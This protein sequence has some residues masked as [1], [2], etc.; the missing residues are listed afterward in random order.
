MI[1]NPLELKPQHLDAIHLIDR[2][3]LICRNTNQT[4]NKFGKSMNNLYEDA[5][6][7]GF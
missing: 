7:Y 5:R 4:P 3:M 2:F 1:N 6:K